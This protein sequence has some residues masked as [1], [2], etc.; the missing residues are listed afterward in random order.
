MI[1]ALPVSA[2]LHELRL[3]RRE[4]LGAVTITVGLAVA[5]MVASPRKGNPM[6][7]S[8]G[9]LLVVVGALVVFA[10]L[11]GRRLG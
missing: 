4:R 8:R 1:F 9:W 7:P 10:L 6:A 2:R 3:G 5:A 11:A